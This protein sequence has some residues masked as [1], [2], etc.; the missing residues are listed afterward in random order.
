MFTTSAIYERLAYFKIPVCNKTSPW[1]SEKG[2]GMP[3][4]PEEPVGAHS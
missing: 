1:H 3:Y 4:S 2:K